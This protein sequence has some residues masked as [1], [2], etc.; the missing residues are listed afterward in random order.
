VLDSGGMQVT[1]T[2][3]PGRF[4]VTSDYSL[5]KFN[6]RCPSGH[7]WYSPEPDAWIGSDC[8]Y[9]VGEGKCRETLEQL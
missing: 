9:S 3:V 6:L 8:G 4:K 1:N 7:R 5:M 2:T